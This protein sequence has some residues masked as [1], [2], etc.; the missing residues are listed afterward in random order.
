MIRSML[1]ALTMAVVLLATA[2]AQ[3]EAKN[4]ELET[5]FP[6]PT[7]G[8]AAPRDGIERGMVETV[9]YDSTT[10]GVKRKA[11]VYT[12]PGYSKD[13]RYP[14]LYLLHGIGGDENEWT[15]GGAANVVLEFRPRPPHAVDQLSTRVGQVTIVPT[16][17]ELNEHQGISLTAPRR[18]LSGDE[19]CRSLG[20]GCPQCRAGCWPCCL[21]P[22]PPAR[23][24]AR[25]RTSY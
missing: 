24:S 4:V 3:Q 2:Q 21:W 20:I 17:L 5:K 7:E 1:L 14:V 8:F 11:Q 19:T 23:P 18:R 6:P 22:P 25:R 15:R 13:K 16:V 12:P 10:V 9:E